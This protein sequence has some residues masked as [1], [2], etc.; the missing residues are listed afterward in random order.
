MARYTGP[1]AKL[2]RRFGENI[3]GAPKYDR[4]LERKNYA[5]GEHGPSKSF[6]KKESD[7]AVHLKEKQKLRLMYGLMEKQF[8]NYYKKASKMGGVTGENLMQLLEMRLDNL[9]FR[10]GL[11]ATRMQARQIVRHGHV[12]VND[13]RVNIPS[14]LCKVSDVIQIREKSRKVRMFLDNL[15]IRGGS[16]PYAWLSLDK[17]AMKGEVLEIPNRDQIPVDIDDRLIVEFYSK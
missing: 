8:R 16:C 4:I 14:F 13:R 6:R 1:K 17:D 7:Y 2:C 3:F 10:L 9:V 12:T 15:D 11:A 5:P